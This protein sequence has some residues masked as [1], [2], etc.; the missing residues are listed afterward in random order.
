MR[1]LITRNI[2]IFIASLVALTTSAQGLTVWQDDFEG[3]TVGTNTATNQTIAGTTVATANTATSTVVNSTTDPNA[4]TAFTLASGNFIRISVG[5][6]EY[7]SIRSA[8]DPIVFPAVS[9]SEPFLFSFDL[10]IPG[11]TNLD[12]PV[13][14]ISPRLESLDAANNGSTFTSSEVQAPGQYTI[15]YSGTVGDFKNQ[16]SIGNVDS[17]RPLIIVEQKT[18]AS[19]NGTTNNFVYLDNIRLEIGETSSNALSV[20]WGAPDFDDSG[21][22]TGIGPMGY[23]TSS[24]NPFTLGTNLNSMRGN[25]LSLYMRTSFTLTAQQLASITQLQLTYDYDD[26]HIAYLNGKEINRGNMGVEGTFYAYN[27]GADGT[28]NG[29]GDNGETFS[30]TTIRVDH[31]HLVVGKN[32]LSGQVH[33]A[34]LDS[35]DLILYMELENGSSTIV[36]SDATYAYFIGTSEPKVPV[37]PPASLPPHGITSN[38]ETL[39]QDANGLPDIWEALY[40]AE[41]IAPDSDSDGDGLSNAEEAIFG[42]NPF[43][44]RSSFEFKITAKNSNT[45][46]VSWTD[47]SDRPGILQSSLDLGTSSPW[48]TQSRTPTRANGMW[49]VDLPAALQRHFFRVK[50]SSIDLDNDGVPDWLEPLIGF[51]STSG[52]SD[53]VSRP[54]SYDLD[55][56]GTADIS[57]SGDLAAFNEI[58]R[59]PETGKKLTRAQA[60]RLLLQG[61]FGP[62]SMTEVDRVASIGTEAWL[63]EQIA[64]PASYTQPYIDA[65]KADLASSPT[66]QTTSNTLSGYNINSG[67]TP[68]VAGTNYMTAWMRSSLRGEDQLRQRV[69]FALSQI[70]VGSRKGAMLGNQPRSTA[71]YYDYMVA[72]SFG[73]FEELLLKV[74]LSPFMGHYLSHLRNEKADPSI[75]RYPD[76][77]YAREIM[78]LFTIGLWE[79]NPDGTRKLDAQGEPIPTYT[80]EDITNLAKVFTGTDYSSNSFG[81]GW[82]EDGDSTGQYM[83][84]PMKVYA[85]HHDFSSKKVPQGVNANGTRLY[86]TIPARSATNT[87]ALQDVEDVV[88]HLVRHP[89]TAPF[90]CR[91]LIQFLIT[92]N[93]SPDYVGRVASV[94]SDNG[95]GETGDLE[96]V[97]E[98]IFLDDEA[99]NPMNHLKTKYFGHFREPTLRTVHLARL[100]KIDRHSQLLWWD[101]GYYS[102]Q[103]L[104]EPMAAPSVFNYYRPDYRLFGPLANQQLDSPA[105]GIVNSYSSI[106]FTNYLWKICLEGFEHPNGDKY[107]SNKTFP[108]DYSELLSMANNIP[109]LLDH[110]SILYCAGTLGAESRSTITTVLQS[111]PDLTDRARL[112]AFLVLISPEGTCLK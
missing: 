21:W 100:L 49:N 35:S 28:R 15:T 34:N 98:A 47:L 2:S 102:E 66:G 108:P 7:S 50:D 6:N 96:S 4:A 86:H 43:D 25:Q 99:R 26:G 63:K 42:T 107:Y 39:D 14:R 65:I 93:P 53:S 24:S 70:L 73:N 30:P 89:N 27:Q 23:D 18:S 87:N 51:S 20:S 58:Y 3:A 67:G 64:L 38:P 11:N 91:Q 103:S 31:S 46:T 110:L 112:A 44:P 101:W 80:N 5:D 17:I 45:I 106:S 33:N 88:H 62:S 83:T 95:S 60:A 13:G 90:I 22:S 68:Y 9:D 37:P 52:D 36:P 56:N 78:Q 75:G 48:V 79:L 41:G 8:A 32:T 19:D 111:E 54:K 92:S 59:T 74:T 29:S 77:N 1:F 85:S 105:L 16:S 109:E 76:E 10:Y 71:Q 94:F 40:S 84:T 104:Q 12:A 69:A 72:E 61:T 97:I 81:N 55:G 57:L 82:R